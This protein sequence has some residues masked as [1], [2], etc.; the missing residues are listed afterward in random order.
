MI[1]LAESGSTKCDAVFLSDEGEEIKRIRTIGFNPY[2]HDRHFVAEEIQKVEEIA[3]MGAKVKQVY[4]YGAGC[5]SP[6]LNEEVAI[7]LK[8]GF[9]NAEIFVDHDLRASAYATWNGDPQ[10]T[11]ILGTGS[12]CVYYDGENLVPGNSGYGFIIG[13]EGS[14]S[15]IGKRLVRAYLYHQMNETH[16][17][18][19]EQTFQVDKNI[20]RDNVYAPA[21]A[22]VFLGSFAPF[23]HKYLDDA[24]YYQIVFN[25]FREFVETQVL[26]FPE[27][28]K[29]P[30]SFV[31]SIAHHFEPVLNDVLD[32]FDLKKGRI[33]RR[34]VD[35][36]IDFH[37]RDRMK[38]KTS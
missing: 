6:E 14:A 24:F 3:A 7:G 12:N 33:I 28:R 23:A 16:R 25:G 8:A 15:Y 30:I 32:F 18:E 2:F 17:R 31:G 1:Y 19:F 29:V 20:I 22:N 34:P 35:G 13:D 27:S 4:F 9:P 21:G 10:I 26:P 38:L 5:S 36:L 11:C 37:R